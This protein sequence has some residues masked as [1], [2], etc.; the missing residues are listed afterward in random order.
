M[1]PIFLMADWLVLSRNPALT[2]PGPKQ[3]SYSEFIA[4]VRAGHLAEVSITDTTYAKQV[5]T[6]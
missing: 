6:R 4:E 1:I 5:F 3:V 2:P